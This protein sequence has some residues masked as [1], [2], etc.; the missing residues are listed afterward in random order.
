MKKL[1]EQS[2]RP[3]SDGFLPQKRLGVLSPKNPDFWWTFQFPSVIVTRITKIKQK[4]HHVPNSIKKQLNISLK[5][6]ILFSI[7]A[8]MAFILTT[9]YRLYLHW[10]VLNAYSLFFVLI[11]HTRDSDW[12][13]SD[14]INS[15]WNTNRRGILLF[16]FFFVFPRSISTLESR[17]MWT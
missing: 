16:T 11:L 9:F 6:C 14:W 4:L 12:I 1:N 17:K 2:D 10:C 8:F 13:N 7:D 3:A 15:D 5:M